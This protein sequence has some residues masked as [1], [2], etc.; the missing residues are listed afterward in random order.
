MS[1][2]TGYAHP[3]YAASFQGV[4]TP[5][6]LP[7]SGGWIVQ[8]EIGGTTASDAMGCY[9]VFACGDWSALGRDLE[10]LE[11]EVVSLSLVTD[12][13]GGF[14]ADEL[15]RCFPDLCVP[16]KE[17]FVADLS[18]EP[19]SFVDRHHQ[20]NARRALE[21]VEVERC[22]PGEA[23]VDEWSALYAHLIERHGIRGISAFSRAAFERQ[24]AVPGLT[25]FRARVAGET[26]G[27]ILW[28]E[29]GPVAYYHLAAYSPAGYEA[30]ASFA[31]FHAAIEH[32][33]GRGVGWLSLGAGAGT[34][35]DASDGLTRFKRGW[36]TGTRT[37]YLCG[38]I[39]DPERY[40][41]IA[42]S[43]GAGG[44]TYFPA[45]RRGEFA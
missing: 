39:L 36:S 40:E 1:A 18:R 31:L 37:A 19:D 38:R 26:A 20:R 14:A 22:E 21:R 8:R 45:Y 13:F 34:S 43:R 44:T 17:H 6:A 25:A 11:G 42:R 30:R 23:G 9:P 15:E 27:M 2:M 28:Y 32:F 35:N 3:G 7:E 10:A 4:G 12:P 24:L 29:Q 5:R 41:A 33:A 16:F